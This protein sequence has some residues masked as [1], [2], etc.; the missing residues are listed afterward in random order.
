[1][2]KYDPVPVGEASPGTFVAL[3]SW[4]D[5]RYTARIMGKSPLFVLFVVLTLGFGIGANTTVFT[6]IN[7]LILNPLPVPDPSRLAA[8]A[9]TEPGDTAKSGAPLPISYAGSER[10]SGANRVFRS[11]A[12]YSLR[13]C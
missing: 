2:A 10:L 1:M 4:G 6:L 11:L 13:T 8:L 7:T 3:M 12:G 9:E 5:L